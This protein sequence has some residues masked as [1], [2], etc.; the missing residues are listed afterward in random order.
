MKDKRVLF[1][2][3]AILGIGLLLLGG[4]VL[5]ADEVKML[6]GL[7]IGLGA[8]MLAIGIGSLVQSFI[9]SPAKKTEILKRKNILVN[10]ERNARIREKAG[11]MTAK[12]MN[13]VLSVFVLVLG[14]MRADMKVII[15]AV[16][17]I[18]IEFIFVLFYSNYYARRM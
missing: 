4:L 9:L 13:Y 8:A 1:A 17:L 18:V 11:Y 12:T 14:F 10:D 7:C 6:S 16:L 15:L 2:G 3:Q 5:T